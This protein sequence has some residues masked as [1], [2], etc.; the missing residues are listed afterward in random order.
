M[1]ELNLYLQHVPDANFCDCIERAVHHNT[2][3]EERRQK[4]KDDI[5]ISFFE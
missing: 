3:E 2:I 5:V 4:K 1:D